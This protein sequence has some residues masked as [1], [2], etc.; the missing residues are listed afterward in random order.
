[1]ETADSTT[2]R[3]S[4]TQLLRRVLAALL[5]GGTAVVAAH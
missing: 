2:A 4:A 3:M 5:L 1:V